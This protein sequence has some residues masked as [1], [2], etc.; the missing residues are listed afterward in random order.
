ME[1]DGSEDSGPSHG[2]EHISFHSI[3]AIVKGLA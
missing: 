2:S 3:W 1:V